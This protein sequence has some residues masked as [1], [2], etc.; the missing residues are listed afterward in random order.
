M[1]NFIYQIK[2]GKQLP[3]YREK[4]MKKDVTI[5]PSR[6]SCLQEATSQVLQSWYVVYIL[7]LFDLMVK[8]RTFVFNS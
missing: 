8:T 1:F 4:C 5:L 3:W 7:L 6:F 2:D